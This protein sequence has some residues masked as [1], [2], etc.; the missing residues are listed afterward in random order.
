MCLGPEKSFH[1][2][3][4]VVAGRLEMTES[5]RRPMLSSLAAN[6]TVFIALPL[7][8]NGVIFGLRWDRQSGAG[9]EHMPGIPPGWVVAAIWM[10]LF[11]CMGFARCLLVKRNAGHL[12][13]GP[14]VLAF[15]CLIYPLY[16]AGLQN[17]SVGLVGN[18]ATAAIALPL[19]VLVWRWSRVAS[20][21]M[22]AVCMW[23]LYAAGA[24]AYGLYR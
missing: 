20:G 3:I 1:A 5:K 21:C 16:T 19:A 17:V 11:T 7:L 23:L 6:L 9:S 18:I 2:S 24:T 10:A 8:L 12:I 15:L 22:A 14:S 4:I 13:E